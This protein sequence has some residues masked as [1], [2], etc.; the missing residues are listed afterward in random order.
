MTWPPITG[1]PSITSCTPFLPKAARRCALTVEVTMVL[2][3]SS[4]SPKPSSSCTGATTTLALRS[5]W[6][7]TCSDHCASSAGGASRDGTQSATR[8]VPLA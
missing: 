3:A 2:P 4:S 6:R 5:A 8:C 7:S 1:A